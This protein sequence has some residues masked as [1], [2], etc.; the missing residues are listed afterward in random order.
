MFSPFKTLLKKVKAMVLNKPFQVYSPVIK[1]VIVGDGMTGKSSI[2]TMLE[3]GNR[4]TNYR[5]TAFKSCLTSITTTDG[6]V[7]VKLFN[8]FSV[9]QLY[10]L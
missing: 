6:K 5:T 9:I 7:K 3:N 1:L 2:I 4:I 8:L 10:I